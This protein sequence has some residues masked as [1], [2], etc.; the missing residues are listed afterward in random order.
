MDLLKVVPEEGRRH[1]EEKDN[2]P[3][4]RTSMIKY[5]VMEHRRMDDFQ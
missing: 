5:H 1:D 4:S 2:D 3:R